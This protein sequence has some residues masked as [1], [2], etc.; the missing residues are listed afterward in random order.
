MRHLLQTE[1]QR[2]TALWAQIAPHEPTADVTPAEQGDL[3]NQWIRIA[4]HELH[5]YKAECLEIK[6]AFEISHNIP[7]F[8]APTADEEIVFER[9]CQRHAASYIIWK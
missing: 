2:L 1:K 9:D 5:S 3:A 7:G 4:P 6:G 8:F